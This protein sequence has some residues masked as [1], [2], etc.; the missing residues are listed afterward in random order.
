MILYTRGRGTVVSKKSRIQLLKKLSPPRRS[1]TRNIRG[2]FGAL[3]RARWHKPGAKCHEAPCWRGLLLYRAYIVQGIFSP[4]VDLSTDIKGTSSGA[5][6]SSEEPREIRWAKNVGRNEDARRH[7]RGTRVAQIRCISCIFQHRL[8]H[9][10][11]E[12]GRMIG[13]ADRQDID[14][15][16]RDVRPDRDDFAESFSLRGSAGLVEASCRSFDVE[17]HLYFRSIPA[18]PPARFKTARRR[19]T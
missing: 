7:A 12:A 1:Y 3:A 14:I 6:S 13:R 11:R 2:L 16:T 18:R 9:R 10:A 5:L 4:L 8:S 15:V 17:L 19:Y